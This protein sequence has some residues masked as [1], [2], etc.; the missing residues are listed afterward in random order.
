ME[1]D[2]EKNTYEP[3]GATVP[4]KRE[5]AKTGGISLQDTYETLSR[6]ESWLE[7]GYIRDLSQAKDFS[8]EGLKYKKITWLQLFRLPISPSSE[9]LYDLTSYWQNALAT[10]NVWGNKFV[11]LLLRKG[12]ETNIFF[13]V[14]SNT[15]TA[16]DAVEQL[17]QVT[18]AAIPGI[19]VIPLDGKK[20]EEHT[21]NKMIT[22]KLMEFTALGTI[23]GL[24]SLREGKGENVQTL[25]A[26]AFGFKGE[27]SEFTD[28]AVVVIAEPVAENEI[29]DMVNSLRNYAERVHGLVKG[30]S[31]ISRGTSESLGKSEGKSSQKSLGLSMGHMLPV[32]PS[33]NKSSGENSGTFESRGTSE[34]QSYTVD[35]IN[36]RAE[37]LEQVLENYITRLQRGRNLGFWNTGVYAL[38][39]TNNDVKTVLGLLKSI[40]SGDNSYIEPIRANLIRDYEAT[41]AVKSFQLLPYPIKGMVHPL[42]KLFSHVSTP[43][44]TEELS[45]A[46][47][48]PRR[49]VPGVRFSKTAV[50]FATNPAPLEDKEVMEIGSILDLGVEQK[51]KYYM[52]P[53][54]L[55]RHALVAGCT[56]SGKS[57]TCK[58]FL[59]EI[60]KRDIPSL[61]IEP[62][63]DDYV[64]WAIA[65]NKRID[66]DDSLTEEEKDARKWDIYMPG[67]NELDGYKLK[68][69]KINPFEPAAI[70]GAPID[71]M[72]RY[73]QVV[74]IINASVPASDVLPVLIDETIYRF[75]RDYF[76]ED[77]QKTESEQRQ[78]YPKISG[79]LEVARK[80]LEERNYDKKVQ[81]D[82][83]AALETR[84]QYLSRGKRGA[85]LDVRKSV[86]YGRL[87]GHK[88]V[89]N[90]SRLIG[91]KD[92]ALIMSFLIVALYEYRISAFSYDE[93]YRSRA[94]QN[95]LMHLT[96]I[97]E[98]HNLLQNPEY[99]IGGTGNPQ[100]VSAE[101]FTNILSEIRSYGQGL[102]IVDQ[103]PTRLIPDAVKNTNYKI[104]HR[105]TAADDAQV[106]A[107]SMAL[108]PEQ[109]GVI[110]K[111]RIGEAIIFGD[112]DDAALWVKI[113]RSEGN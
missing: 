14:A 6:L 96:L 23:T 56:G 73:E 27:V 45:I 18:S 71:L 72:S 97:E 7:R 74:T 79:I 108:M 15:Q 92:K 21:T 57:T 95:K 12:G 25:D 40:Y 48:L 103:V 85:I 53:D 109:A 2:M 44:N 9:E 38:A 22:D 61:I 20:D 34:T 26:L 81:N 13:G 46:T 36:K 43:M 69:L 99:D 19:E 84:F 107:A 54:A 49:D 110:S 39:R 55:V 33:V 62:A 93:A 11:F 41:E 77:F 31:S 90:L 102:I 76:E 89:V 101:M 58:K 105:L 67:V 24:P 94:N 17:R 32:V 86:D 8:L 29:D 47:S 65:Y 4:E 50:R 111:L 112:L 51:Q 16:G 68:K 10:F 100:K 66:E 3:S 60:D 98:A 78:E 59:S 83:A 70:Q 35:V 104:I 52:S 91:T 64:R 1:V 63:K 37:Y 30:S 106:V 87:F 113:K 5:G 80:V 88:S 42:G 82:M 28:Y 75:M